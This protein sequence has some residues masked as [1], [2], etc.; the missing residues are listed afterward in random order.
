MPMKN[1]ALQSH[2]PRRTPWEVTA[3]PPEIFFP[4]RPHMYMWILRGRKSYSL[5]PLF[6]INISPKVRIYFRSGSDSVWR[7]ED[8]CFL[9]LF[10]ALIDGAV[11]Y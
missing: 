7:T 3:F 10:F 1:S 4:K 2:Q 11:L 8:F 5:S 9:D 6:L